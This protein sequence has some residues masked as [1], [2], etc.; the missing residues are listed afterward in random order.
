MKYRVQQYRWREI[1]YLKLESPATGEY[2]LILPAQGGAIHQI[3]LCADGELPQQIL[4][5]DAP[6]EISLNPWFRGR[7]LFPFDDRVQAG[8]YSFDGEVY[9]LPIN[10]P[11]GQ[12]ALHGFLY[13]QKLEIV[14]SE[15]TQERATAVLE[16]EV[17]TEPGYPFHLHIRLQYTLHSKGFQ[18]D[19]MTGNRG[20]AA[21]PFSVGWHPY[22][23]L[24]AGNADLLKLVIPAERYIETDEKLIPSGRLLPVE[25][26]RLDFR[27][28]SA[29]GARQLDHGFVNPAGYMECSDENMKIRIEQ[30]PLFAYSQVFVPPARSSVALEPISAATDAFNKPELGLRVLPPG[31][32]EKGRIAVSLCKA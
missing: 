27:R 5:C 15:A 11:E 20:T 32:S 7:V 28:P 1:R 6:E 17:A 25:G 19:L 21:A 3:A 10:D 30:S 18:L 8:R 29:I 4:D 14:L 16:G 12:D 24:P 31:E 13:A 9:Q 23:R 26:S 2:V 22:F